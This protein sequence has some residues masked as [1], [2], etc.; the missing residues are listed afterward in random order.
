MLENVKA[1]FARESRL[2]DVPAP[3]YVFGDIHGNFQDLLY[4]MSNLIPFKHIKYSS[5]NYVFLGDYVDRGRY[6]V[7]CVAYLIALKVQAPNKVFLLR[8]NHEDRR[9]NAKLE[10]SYLKHCIELFGKADGHEVWEKTNEVFDLMP[11][12][13]VIDDKLFCAHGGV[14]RTPIDPNTGKLTPIRQLV[15]KVQV[16]LLD[17]NDSEDHLKQLACDLLWADPSQEK[18]IMM[19]E[20]NESRGCS[21]VFGQEA[22]EE[23]LEV[24]KFESIFRAHQWF[25]FG[26]NIAKSAKVITLFTSSNYCDNNSCAGC[27]LVAADKRIQLLMK[28]HSPDD[29]SELK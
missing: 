25:S 20:R 24:N 8:G 16:P 22:I 10:E 11:L 29:M 26:V 18:G 1:I 12:C 2:V 15:N 3:S 19:F 23:F 4:F 13:A 21:C 6:D 5:H 14:P 17:I 27:A 28:E 7:E 9:Q